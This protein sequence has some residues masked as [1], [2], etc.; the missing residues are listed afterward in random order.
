MAVSVMESSFSCQ[1]VS[2]MLP[3][4]TFPWWADHCWV[5]WVLVRACVDGVSSTW[6][7]G[8]GSA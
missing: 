8:S 4:N 1:N 7:S 3:V 2:A 5:R 6:D